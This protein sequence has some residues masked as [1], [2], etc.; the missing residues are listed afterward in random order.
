ML[1]QLI[2]R[3]WNWLEHVLRKNANTSANRYSSGHGTATEEYGSQRI[4][5][6][7]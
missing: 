3:K 4:L 2:V 1:D 5:G 7:V 6:N